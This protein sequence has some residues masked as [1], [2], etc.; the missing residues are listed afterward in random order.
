MPLWGCQQDV[1]DI[2]DL[3]NRTPTPERRA[4]ASTHASDWTALGVAN[5]LQEAKRLP[6]FVEAGHRESLLP[7]IRTEL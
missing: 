7:V 2:A 4:A 5:R 6:L 3:R 1:Q